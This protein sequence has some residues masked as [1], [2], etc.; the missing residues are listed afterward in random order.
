MKTTIDGTDLHVLKGD[1]PT[2][3]PGCILGHEGGGASSRLDQA[4]PPFSPATMH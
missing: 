3:K 2:C 4:L 1:G